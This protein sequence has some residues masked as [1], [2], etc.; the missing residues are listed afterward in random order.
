MKKT[1]MVMVALLATCA[2]QAASVSWNSGTLYEPNG[3]GTFSGTPVGSGSS[4]SAIL[5]VYTDAGGTTLVT[6]LAGN[7]DNSTSVSSAL[8]GTATATAP[9]FAASTVY[10][11]KLVV[12]STDGQWIQTSSLASFTMPP[13]SNANLN[14]L[15]GTGFDTVDNKMPSQWTA[16]PEP[17]SM[18]LF[19]VGFGVMALRR[20]FNNK[21]V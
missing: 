18:A 3:N 20:R 9:A 21:K 6:G 13:V 16:V 14:F 4:Y 2:A 5:Y 8:N 17:C 15:N 7:T 10:Y 11:A 1:M 12:T 19:G